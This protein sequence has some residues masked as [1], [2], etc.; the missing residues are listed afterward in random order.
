MLVSGMVASCGSKQIF[1]D[2]LHLI[3][4]GEQN[5]VQLSTNYAQKTYRVCLMNMNNH[6]LK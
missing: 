3:D 4:K 1:C 5:P 6:I 2:F